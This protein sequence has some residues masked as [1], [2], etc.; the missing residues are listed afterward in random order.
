MDE[1]DVDRDEARE[2]MEDILDDVRCPPIRQSA[3]GA[4]EVGLVTEVVLKSIVEGVEGIGIDDFC[5][6]KGSAL[7]R[8]C[9]DGG[10][11]NNVW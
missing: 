4:I 5:P 1:I 3:P 10:K 9:G 8:R 11:M 7:S 6:S 2:P